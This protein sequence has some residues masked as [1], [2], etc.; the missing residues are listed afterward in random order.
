MET[1]LTIHEYRMQQ[2][3]QI[4]KTCRD[5]GITVKAWCAQNGVHPK[6]Y[7]YWLRKIRTATVEQQ[8]CGTEFVQ[9]GEDKPIADPRIGGILLRVSGC[10]IEI[11]EG[12]STGLIEQT[13]QAIRHA[14]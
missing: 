11:R 6:S 7:Y 3:A 2:W 13:L 8:Q 5:S 12:T 1:R 10:E 14:G 4:I 9:I